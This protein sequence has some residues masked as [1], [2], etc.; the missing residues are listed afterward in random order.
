MISV[1]ILNAKV[2]NKLLSLQ[3]NVNWKDRVLKMQ[4]ELFSKV[5]KKL[6]TFF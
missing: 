1:I 5:V 2:Q 4:G 3:D 6:G